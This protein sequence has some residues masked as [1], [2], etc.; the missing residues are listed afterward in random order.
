[1]ALPFLGALVSVPVAAQ[2]TAYVPTHKSNSVAV[3]DT[4]LDRVIAMVPVQVQLLL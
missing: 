4:M 2:C 3:I 1:L